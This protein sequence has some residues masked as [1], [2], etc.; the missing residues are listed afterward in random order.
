MTAP[1]HQVLAMRWVARIML[2]GFR[3]SSSGRREAAAAQL[4]DPLHGLQQR[5]SPC[6]P[7]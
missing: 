7:R 1:R 5:S 6:C 3:R 2:A 4:E